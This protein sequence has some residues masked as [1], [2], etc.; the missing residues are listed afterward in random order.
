VAK[1]RHLTLHLAASV[2]SVILFFSPL[3]SAQTL[4]PRAYVVTPVDTNAFTVTT[5]LYRGDILFDNSVPIEDASGTISLSVPTFYH[6][7][8]FFRRSASV[9]VGLPYALASLRAR[10]VDQQVDTYRS[11][12]GDGAVR[13]SVN[14]M[15]GPA[16]KLPEFMKWKQKRLLGVSIVVQAPTGQY[17]PRLLINVGN[18][19]WVIHPELGYSERHGNWL[20]DIYSGVIFFTKT[21]EFFSHNNFVPGKQERTQE[22]VEVV[23]GHLSY[24]FKPR[25]W[26]SLDGNFWYGGRT[27][28]NGVEN[29]ASLQKN[30]RVGAT[31]AI[32][33]TLH[34]SI[35]FSYDRGAVIRFGGKYQ[36]VAVAWQYG[37]IGSLWPK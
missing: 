17:D 2:A 20:V 7:L 36:A 34:Q 8:T 30:S 32:P 5:N 27:T 13:F 28:L 11:G 23:E 10:V 1:F 3:V 35:K 14:L 29:R 37:W 12:L 21:P 18:S 26:V 9:T 6:S 19:R 31:A 15:G 4:A 22:P 24:D 16:M 33:I 25:L